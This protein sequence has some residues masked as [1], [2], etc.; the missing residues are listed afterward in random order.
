MNQL[1]TSKN[2][3]NFLCNIFYLAIGFCSAMEFY[4]KYSTERLY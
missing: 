4:L 1:S 3:Y 2:S